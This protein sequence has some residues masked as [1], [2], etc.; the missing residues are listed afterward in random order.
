MVEVIISNF[1]ELNLK[2]KLKNLNPRGMSNRQIT[3]SEPKKNF[4]EIMIYC[5]K[6][7]LKIILFCIL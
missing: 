6:S 5:F 3:R 1:T 4:L 2:A 7:I